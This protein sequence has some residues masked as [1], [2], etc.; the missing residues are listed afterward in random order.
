MDDAVPTS[1]STDSATSSGP[2]G[3]YRQRFATRFTAAPSLG[4]TALAA[5]PL[6]TALRIASHFGDPQTVTALAE[7]CSN[8]LA[9]GAL[10][11]MKWPECAGD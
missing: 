5:V 7:G 11:A 10:H 6:T 1:S 9:S 2:T 3:Q 4:L 8:A